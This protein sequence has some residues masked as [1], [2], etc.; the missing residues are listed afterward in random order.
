MNTRSTPT[1]N[2]VSYHHS[3]N[4]KHPKYSENSKPK[5]HLCRLSE[6]SPSSFRDTI[7]AISLRRAQSCKFGG[8]GKFSL[9]NGRDRTGERREQSWSP[10]LQERAG[11]PRKRSQIK[12]IQKKIRIYIESRSW[13]VE[14]GQ[15]EFGGCRL[16]LC[17]FAARLPDGFS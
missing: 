8:T 1:S 16:L 12:T 4:A 10:L 14:I 6:R 13:T 7:S 17:V 3:I 5:H 15:S 11:M 9:S 2:I